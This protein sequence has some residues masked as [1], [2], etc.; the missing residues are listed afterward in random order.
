MEG[1][2]VV[3]VVVLDGD[4]CGRRMR[5]GFESWSEEV[6]RRVRVRARRL[7]WAHTSSVCTCAE[8]V[9]RPLR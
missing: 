9:A 3:H 8:E 2:V 7:R 6:L 5:E 1:F 4:A